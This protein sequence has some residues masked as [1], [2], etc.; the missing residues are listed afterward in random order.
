[1]SQH[2]NHHGHDKEVTIET[3]RTPPLQIPPAP[4]KKRFVAGLV[5]SI[6]IGLVWSILIVT[7]RLAPRSELAVHSVYLAFV[8]LAYYFLQEG[9]FA[10]TIGKHM[11]GLRV[12]G[13]DGDPASLREALI[14]NLLRFVDWLPLL[15]VIGIV[16]LMS[17]RQRRRLGDVVARTVVTVAPQKDINPPPAPF[18]FH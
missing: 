2:D 18:L 4:L 15:Y 8:A 14:R 11:V 3:L 17:S 7:F 5:D 13:K 1:M 9:I 12:I 10:S 6:V 16:A